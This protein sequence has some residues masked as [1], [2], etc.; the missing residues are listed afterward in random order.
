MAVTALA[1]RTWL[2]VWGVKT[3]RA[4]SFGSDQSENLHR[5]TGSIREA[6]GAFGKREKAE[7]E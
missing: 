7:E 2:G 4:R 5:G 3:M 1:A 6:G